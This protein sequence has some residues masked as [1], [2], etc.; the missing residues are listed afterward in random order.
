MCNMSLASAWKAFERLASNTEAL[1]E[2]C[3]DKYHDRKEFCCDVDLLQSITDGIAKSRDEVRGVCMECESNG[4]D[5]VEPTCKHFG[6][7]QSS[8]THT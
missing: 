4:L 1:R 5:L 6:A 2:K 8:K 7:L 3:R